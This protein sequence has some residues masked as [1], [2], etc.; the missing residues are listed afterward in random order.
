M[1]MLWKGT[2]RYGL[3]NM[4]EAMENISLKLDIELKCFLQY[5]VNEMKKMDG[6]MFCEIWKRAVKNKLHNTELNQLDINLI[7]KMGDILGYLDKE[8]Q[9]ENLNQCLLDIDGSIKDFEYE[10]NNKSKLYRTLSVVVGLFIV[11][12]FVN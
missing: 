5:V 11:I 1:I 6:D 12:I 8:L 4:S 10:L 3:D 7:N 9:I 2:I